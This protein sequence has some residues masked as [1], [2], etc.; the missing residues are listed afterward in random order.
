MM[1]EKNYIEK[2]AVGKPCWL[3]INDRPLEKFITGYATLNV[4]GRTTLPIG[5]SVNTDVP[6]DG[7]YISSIKYKPR[8]LEVEYLLQA[9]SSMELYRQFEL[10][11]KALQ[12]EN[13]KIFYSDD[14]Y[15]YIGVVTNIEEIKDQINRVVGHFTVTCTDVFKY[16]NDLRKID[17]RHGTLNHAGLYSVLPEKIH[18]ASPSG[19]TGGILKN[20]TSGKK[21]TILDAP[22]SNGDKTIVIDVKLGTITRGSE[23]LLPYLDIASNLEDFEINNGD[24]ISFMCKF[25]GSS[26]PRDF[27]VFYRDRRL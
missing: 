7:G 14:D 27:E 24:K 9:D 23:N 17:R 12:G 21:I 1:D 10:L 5:A 18:L 2:E 11:N 8:F 4:F 6:Y 22:A 3:Y 26:T 20:E 25:Y 13:I 15:F 16:S 19:S